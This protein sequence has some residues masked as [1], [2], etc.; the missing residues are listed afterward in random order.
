MRIKVKKLKDDA[1]LPT[2]AHPG[3]VGMDMYAMETVT[4]PPMGHHIFWHGFAL[5]FA[6]GYAGIVKDKSSISKAGLHTMGGVYDAGYRGEYNTHLVNLSSEPY[7]VEEGDKV[8]QLVILPV[9]IAELERVETLSE[10][11]RGENGFGSTGK[12]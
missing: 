3:D 2:Y 7:T 6:E 10:S 9:V 12:K 4:I 11:T 1:K 8:G 5:E